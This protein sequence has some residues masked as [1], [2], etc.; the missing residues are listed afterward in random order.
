MR[1]NFALTVGSRANINM[2]AFARN[3]DPHMA[4]MD[5]AGNTEAGAG[6]EHNAAAVKFWSAV[7]DGCE[8][9][10]VKRN[11]RQSLRFKIIDHNDVF[12]AQTGD[13]G[14]GFDHPR[15]IGQRNFIA[16]NRPCNRQNCSAR[17]Q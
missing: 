17:L 6:T 10:L 4:R 14:A 7:A 1:E 9:I 11:N 13:H 16:I 8:V 5:Q 3:R 15:T 12:E 2:P